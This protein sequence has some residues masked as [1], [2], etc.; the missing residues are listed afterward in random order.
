MTPSRLSLGRRILNFRQKYG[1]GLGVAYYRDRVRQRILATAPVDCG[2]DK[3]CEMHVLTSASDWLNLV[4]TLKSFYFYSGR[5]YS[6]CI[7]DDGTLGSDETSVLKE[8]FPGARLVSRIESDR[9]L[10]AA[11]APYPRCLEFR[12]SNPLSP[13][14]FDFVHY[15]DAPRLLLVDSDVLFF[16][17]PA[18]L[19]RRI[20]DRA[21]KL[22]TVNTDVGNG[23]TV[24]PEAVK[25]LLNLE[26]PRRFN[27]GLG[28]IHRE[29]MRLD[30]IEEFLGLPGIIGHFWRIEQTIY[31]L[32]SARFGVELL[33]DEYTVRLERGID[34]KPC[35]H[36]VGAIRHL[37]YGEGIRQL[38]RQ[39]FLALQGTATEVSA[40]V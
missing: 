18:E 13:K 31:A 35:R 25:R 20:D 12:R 5:K 19:L 26:M 30:W 1:R 11:L 32:S 3:S 33:P 40:S 24:E 10:E 36:Y 28:L 22:N 21:Y 6:L 2:A 14:V 7:H 16:R 23:Y 8:Q 34:G 4:W 17:E 9:T 39:R 38:V 37:M 29:S 27:S 15:L